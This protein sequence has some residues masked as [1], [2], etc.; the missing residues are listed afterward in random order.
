M[1]TFRMTRI[2]KYWEVGLHLSSLLFNKKIFLE[3]IVAYGN[4][5]ALDGLSEVRVRTPGDA[6][7]IRLIVSEDGKRGRPVGHLPA[8]RV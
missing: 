5:E 7:G 6:A 2:K 3:N 4:Y 8:V 1:L